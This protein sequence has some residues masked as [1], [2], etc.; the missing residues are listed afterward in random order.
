MRLSM[1]P[2]AQAPDRRLI[3]LLLVLLLALAGCSGAESARSSGASPATSGAT[4]T[5]VAEGGGYEPVTVENC[6]TTATFTAP[7]ERAITTGQEGTEILLALG[8]QDRMVGTMRTYNPVLPELQAAFEQVP[9][10]AEGGESAPREV[11]LDARPDFVLAPYVDYDLDPTEGAPSREDLESAGAN[12]YGLSVNCAEDP[13]ATSLQDTYDDILQVG[14]IFGVEDRAEEL[15]AGMQAQ[16]DE[17]A[18]AIEGRPAPRV[19]LYANGEGP[20]GVSGSGLPA[21]L[22]RLA[23]G[24]NVFADLDSTFGEVSL[25]AATERNPQVFATIDYSPGLTPEEKA[26]FLR[27]A[28]PTT[29]AAQ[30]GQVM[31]IPDAAL[32][33]SVRNA[34]LVVE[35]ARALHPDAF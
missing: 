6:G 12:V 34:D 14:R 16:I 33:Q 1:F 9:Q 30:S 8:L 4:E 28:L 3:C 24:E 10:L 29:E 11:V 26:A 7:P 27:E 25:E 23:G 31:T 35:M 2:D 5:T 18:A 20:L 13:S 19:L 22:V 15:V 17:V 32:N 21:D